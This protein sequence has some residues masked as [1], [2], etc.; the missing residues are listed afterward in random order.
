MK[1]KTALSLS[2]MPVTLILGQADKT[3]VDTP[4][5]DEIG[6][7]GNQLGELDLSRATILNQDTLESRQVNSLE[8][9]NGLSPNLHLSGNGIK[10]FGDV[11]TMRGIGNTQFFG[12]PGVQM[13]IDG[14][15]QGNVFSY[16]SDLYGLEAIEVLKGPQGSRF[17]KLA[18]GGA[19]NLVTKKPGKKQTSKVSASYATF[20]TQKYNISS[21]G[22]M[23]EQFSYSLGIQRAL[24]DGFLN[25]TSGRN[26]DSETWNGRLSFHWDGGTGTKATLGASFT[27]HE[28]GAQPL[29]LRNQADFYARSVDEDEFTEIDQNQQFLKLEHETETGTITSITSRNDWDMNPNKLDIDLS[30]LPFDSNNPL[31]KMI[32][33]ISQDQQLWSQELR[34]NHTTDNDLSWTIGGYLSEEKIDGLATRDIA[35]S[36]VPYTPPYFPFSVPTSYV[37]ES[38]NYAGFFIAEKTLTKTDSLSLLLRYDHFEKSMNR[39]NMGAQTHNK[40]KNFSNTSGNINWTRNV[41]K[42]TSY[43]LVF[44]YA[45]KPGGFSAFTGTAGQEVYSDESI[46][47]YEAFVDLNPSES[48]ELRVGAFLND[49]KDYQFELNGAGM[50]YYLEN[51]DEVSIYGLEVDSIWNLGGGWSFGASYGLTE[52]EFK[53]VTALPALVGKHL[54]F[55][56]DHSLSLV[57]GHE[58]DNG[59]SYQIGSRTTGKTHFWDNTGSNTNDVIDSYTLLEAQIGYAFNDWNFNL[60][61]TNLTKEEYYT[62]LVSNLKSPVITDAPGIAGSPRVIGLSISKEF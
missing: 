62:S 23:D 3:N 24:S 5:L 9:L 38:E 35:A 49:V 45:E 61:G 30:N 21:S 42:S 10:S 48:W 26:N 47:S 19:I 4:I 51:A 56:P 18:P 37:L 2:L 52:S 13:Y 25:N 22:P 14:V 50:D 11:L 57:L 41:N 58:L 33:T 20:N 1:L 29:V 17:G 27:S 28:L 8:D 15:P 31:A 12:S 55:V 39:T 60:F 40:S 53:K 7:K 16:G 32:S 46:V 36:A 6:I 34:F 54:P 59:L 43:G 44:G